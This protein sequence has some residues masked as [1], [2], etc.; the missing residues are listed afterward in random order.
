MSQSDWEDLVDMT[1]SEEAAQEAY[2]D[3]QRT[4]SEDD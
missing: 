2:E 1:G 3:A 4:D